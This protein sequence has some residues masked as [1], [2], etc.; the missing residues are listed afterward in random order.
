MGV[1]CCACE[2]AA[3]NY[4][5]E[6]LSA[7]KSPQEGT[8]EPYNHQ[9]SSAFSLKLRKLGSSISKKSFSYFNIEDHLIQEATLA[10]EKAVGF[11]ETLGIFL[12]DEI[13]EEFQQVEKF[14]FFEEFKQMSHENKVYSEEEVVFS[15]MASPS[16]P[17]R[18]KTKLRSKLKKKSKQLKS[19]LC[20]GSSENIFLLDKNKSTED[21][22]E[23]LGVLS[24]HFM[25]KEFTQK[26]M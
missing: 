8:K 10:G 2:K 6:N 11:D 21:R 19:A 12:K 16:N 17:M 14:L 5:E 4:S 23:L 26:E 24:K 9:G 25:F 3:Q 22:I 18:K 20:L 1:N 7:F 13:L 15:P